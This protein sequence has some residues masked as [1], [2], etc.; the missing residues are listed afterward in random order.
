M[1]SDLGLL[2]RTYDAFN[3]HDI[4]AALATMTSDV[5]WPNASAGGR[6]RGHDAVRAYWTRQWDET[7]PIVRLEGFLVLPDARLRLDVRQTVRD[8]TGNL[9][10]EG[11]VGHVYAFRD[12]LIARM[13]IE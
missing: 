12:G 10:S 3:A 5:D 7:E 4:D 6:M 13:D 1:N 2:Y 8:R 9:L 11:L